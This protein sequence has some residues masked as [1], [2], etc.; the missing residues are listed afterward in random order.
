MA[1]QYPLPRKL[2]FKT[3]LEERVFLEDWNKG[4]VVKNYR[5][6]SVLPILRKILERIKFRSSRPE[7]FLQKGVLNMQ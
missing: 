1:S 6:L 3:V 2:L 4:N 5:R 7:V